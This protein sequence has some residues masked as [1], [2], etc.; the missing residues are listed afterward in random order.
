LFFVCKPAVVLFYFL[1]SWWICVH[2]SAVSV[3]RAV[4]AEVKDWFMLHRWSFFRCLIGGKR[5]QIC[6]TE[7]F[8]ALTADMVLFWSFCWVK[9][10]V[11][12]EECLF[13]E[14][15][16]DSVVVS[17]VRV[18]YCSS[19]TNRGNKAGSFTMQSCAHA[20]NTCTEHILHLSSSRY[21]CSLF[22]STPQ[23]HWFVWQ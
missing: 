17:Y 8:R 7:H 20:Q 16:A 13:L 2:C 12:P 15:R 9:Q 22:V 5:S 3:P 19:S 21:M 23:L 14:L 6:E 4:S 11:K 18:I 10:Q 1:G